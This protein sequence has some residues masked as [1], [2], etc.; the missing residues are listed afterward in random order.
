MIAE[1]NENITTDS[2]KLKTKTEQKLDEGMKRKK[3]GAFI[4]TS[5]KV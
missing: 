3:I 5:C 2:V 4:F 1:Q